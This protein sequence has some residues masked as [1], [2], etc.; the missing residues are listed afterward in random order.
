MKRT[1]EKLSHQRQEIETSL[2][3]RIDEIRKLRSR[4][5]DAEAVRAALET[6]HPVQPETGTPGPKRSRK[7]SGRLFG[8]RQGIGDGPQGEFNR[9]V[10]G[11]MNAFGEILTRQ[12]EQTQRLFSALDELPELQAQLAE[13]RDREFDALGSNHVGMIFK[14]MEWRIDKLTAGYNDAAM[15]MKTFVSLRGKLDGLLAALEKGETPD[16][17]EIAAVAHPLEDI[18][19]AGFENRHRGSSEDVR[20]Q[21]EIYL[22]FFTP[23]RKVLDLGCGRG[24]FVALLEEKGI[25][26][27]GFDLNSQMIETCRER[28]LPCRRVDLLDAL[29]EQADGSLGGIFSSQVIEHLRPP[30]LR[31]MIDLARLKLAPGAPLILETINPVSVFALVQTYFL[32]LSHQQPIPPRALQFLMESAGFEEIELRYS[33]P[34]EEERLGTLPTTDEA[35]RIL[36]E[37][38]DKLNELL[39]APANYAA[40]GHKSR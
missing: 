13:A 27:E 18:A 19:Y 8:S 38:T 34:L 7:P 11:A 31:R 32:D 21:Q 29:A 6:L 35:S 9:Q 3:N 26:A 2:K 30:A 4:L 14:S 10:L 23:G 36:N 17:A 28:G 39:Y 16:A 24:E 12:L 22:E 37:N 20:R 25:A 40:I 15:L 5:P 33:A 1:I